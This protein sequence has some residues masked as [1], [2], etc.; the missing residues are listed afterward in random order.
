M[1]GIGLAQHTRKVRPHQLSF[2]QSMRI[3][4]RRN[5]ATMGSS[6]RVHSELAIRISIDGSDRGAFDFPA[7]P[8]IARIQA[9]R[10]SA[11]RDRQL[12]EFVTSRSC[13]SR[14]GNVLRRFRGRSPVRRAPPGT[15]SLWPPTHRFCPNTS[16]GGHR[17]T[18][19]GTASRSFAPGKSGRDGADSEM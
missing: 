19:P 7:L 5:S 17:G 8:R 15:F 2:P 18:D 1:D 12:I 13:Q 14:H 11:Y 9:C 4:R 16:G 10:R 6:V 3:P